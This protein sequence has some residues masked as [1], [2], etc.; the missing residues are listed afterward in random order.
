MTFEELASTLPN[1]FHDAEL[2]SFE[3]NYSSRVLR[4]NLEV[5]IGSMGDP[6][7]TREKYRPATVT[8]RDAA[9]LVVEP[10]DVSYLRFAEADSV[11]IDTGEGRLKNA[12]VSLPDPPAGT[13]LTWMFM[14]SWNSF[15][16]FAAGDS[17]L[18]WTG[19]E[20][21]Y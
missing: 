4:L 20:V 11:S 3:M 17:L 18:E 8:C 2:S 14:M 21:F 16:F 1:R 15:I 7:E 10:P 9:Y 6:P 13:T 12:G 5:W 19:E